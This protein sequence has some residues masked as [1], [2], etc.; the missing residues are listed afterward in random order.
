MQIEADMRPVGDEDAFPT[1]CETLCLELV[2]L[3]EKGWD[4]DDTAGANEVN[5]AGR[6]DE[7]R[8]EDVEVIGD[9]AN[10]DRVPGV[11]T[12]GSSTA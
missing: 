8:G 5:F 6:V 1:A 7:A 11:V 4:M 2:K 12:A 3:F 10:Y 9:V